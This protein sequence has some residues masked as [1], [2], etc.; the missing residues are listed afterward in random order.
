MCRRAVSLRVA[1]V[2]CVFAASGCDFVFRIDRLPTSAD[3]ADRRDDAIDDGAIDA[4]QIT[5]TSPVINTELDG[6]M[7]CTPWGMPYSDLGASVSSG[8]NGLVIVPQNQFNS[9]GGCYSSNN[10]PFG[11][12]GVKAHVTNV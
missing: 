9:V 12:A 10:Q 1:G 7:A 11:M 3:A 4:Q 8:P 2:A 5:C 6:A